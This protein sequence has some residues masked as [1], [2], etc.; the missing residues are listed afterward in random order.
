MCAK[1]PPFGFRKCTR[2][3]TPPPTEEVG[4]G[5]MGRDGWVAT[6]M[7]KDFR[8]VVNDLLNH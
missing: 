7:G 1:K 4:S 2:P 6:V 8:D 3:R 5:G